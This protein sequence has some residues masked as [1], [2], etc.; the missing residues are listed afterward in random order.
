[1]ITSKKKLLLLKKNTSIIDSY[2]IVFILKLVGNY[3][4]ENIGLINEIELVRK[5][6]IYNIIL[7]YEQGLKIPNNPNSMSN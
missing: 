4:K 2:F 1:M 7:W 3:F 5:A 6:G